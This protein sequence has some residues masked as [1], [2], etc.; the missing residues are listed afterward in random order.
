MS[1]T[2]EIKDM[3]GK[4]VSDKQVDATLF[5]DD[6]I[7]ESLVQEYVVMYLAN[8]RYAIAHTKTRGEVTKSGRKLYRQKG[9]GRARVGDAG[10]PI[11]RKGGVVFGPRKNASFSKTMPKKMKKR[12]FISALALKLKAGGVVGLDAYTSDEIKTKV[13]QAMLTQVGVAQGSVVVVLP[14][15]NETIE[16]SLRNIPKV[17]FKRADLLNAYDIMT[18]KNVLFVGDALDRVQQRLLP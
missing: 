6:A 18:N 11:R 1:Y 13:A 10:S 7:N 9:T 5:S 17:T 15:A 16:K 12:A 14:E 8:Q 3:N 4:K 2:V